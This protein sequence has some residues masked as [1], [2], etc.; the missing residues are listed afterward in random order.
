MMLDKIIIV[1]FHPAQACLDAQGQGDLRLRIA[2]RSGRARGIRPLLNLLHRRVVLR[3]Q[4]AELLFHGVIGVG[5]LD[6][7]AGFLLHQVADRGRR[8]RGNQ[9]GQ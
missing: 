4:F 3:Y 1:L 7:K 9:G 6:G 2:R 5:D 8:I